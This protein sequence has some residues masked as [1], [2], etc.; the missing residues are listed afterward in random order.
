[1]D[2]IK[3]IGIKDTSFTSQEGKQINGVNYFYTMRD[4]NVQGLMA[5]KLFISL[6]NLAGFTVQPQLGQDVQVV[7][8]RF[9][10]PEDFLPA[11]N[12]TGV[13]PLSGEEVQSSPGEKTS[14]KK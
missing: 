6:D 10:K 4:N 3:I 14:Q 11:K 8:N 5:G 9:G 1:M 2:T 13:A 7:Y 12:A